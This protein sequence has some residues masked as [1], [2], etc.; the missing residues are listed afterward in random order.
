T[1][2]LCSS[3]QVTGDAAEEVVALGGSKAL[4]MYEGGLQWHTPKEGKV[5]PEI[6]RKDRVLLAVLLCALA[7]LRFGKG[8]VHCTN[9]VPA[10]SVLFTTAPLRDTTRRTMLGSW[11]LG[12]CLDPRPLSSCPH[13]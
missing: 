10:R 6:G 12:R 5:K 3:F 2:L 1:R 8:D 7:Q 13:L 11:S 9:C 4:M